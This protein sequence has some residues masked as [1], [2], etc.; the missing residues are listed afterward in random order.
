MRFIIVMFS[1][2]FSTLSAQTLF[3]RIDAESA[4]DIAAAQGSFVIID[5][6]ANWCGPC[7]T[8]DDQVWSQDTIKALQQNFVNMRVDGSTSNSEFIKY[9]IKSIP[10]LIIIDANGNEYFRR[11]GYMQEKDIVDLLNTFPA[12]MK[13]SYASDYVAQKQPDAFNSHFLRARH[14][15]VAARSAG[16]SIAGR[17]ANTS[18]AAL[19]DAHKVL[20][21]NAE[22][23][24]SLMERLA[25]ME[26]EN[27]LLKGRAKKALKAMVALGES[28][29][30]SNEAYACYVK[31]MAYRKTDRPELASECYDR[32]QEAKDN[33]KF[34]AMYEE[35]N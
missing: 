25:L 9:G 21:A 16:G 3:T 7:K 24:E 30:D 18:S 13:A 15:Q 5:F 1:L 27:L 10:A 8:M 19:K 28:F 31:G 35:E 2:V 14:Y 26:A 12:D 11:N 20:S 17:L 33:E 6:Y 4:K 29:N 22:N 23:P 34:V 32:L